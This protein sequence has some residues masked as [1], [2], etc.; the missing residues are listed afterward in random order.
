[1]TPPHTTP[2]I[3]FASD[4]AGSEPDRECGEQKRT[5][6]YVTTL[7]IQMKTFC[8]KYHAAQ[9]MCLPDGPSQQAALCHP[10]EVAEKISTNIKR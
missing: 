9:L 4:A 2:Y 6:E 7:G 3:A 1:M 10:D 8:Y 5:A